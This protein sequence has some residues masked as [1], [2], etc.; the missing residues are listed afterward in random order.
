MTTQNPIANKQISSEDIRTPEDFWKLTDHARLLAEFSADEQLNF[1]TTASREDLVDIFHDYRF[2][3]KYFI[4][5]LGI[6][7]LKAPFGEFKCMVGHIIADE[8]GHTPEQ[9]HLYLWDKFL[10]SIGDDE[11]ALETPRLPRSEELLASLSHRMLEEPF[12][13]GVGLRGMGAECLCQIYLTAAFEKLKQNPYV[14]ENKDS[15]D[16]VF[17]EIHTGEEDLAHGDMVRKAIDDLLKQRPEE[18]SALTEGYLD[19]KNMWD[20]FWANL[21]DRFGKIA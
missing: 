18:L 9:T 21:Y 16:W 3:I 11:K 4:N 19:A 12:M 2:F 8:L 5:D 15:I 13:Y 17:W 6:L 10:I 7:M 1:L 14:I 20:E